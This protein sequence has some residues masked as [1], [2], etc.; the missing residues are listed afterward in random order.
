VEERVKPN[1]FLPSVIH[2]IPPLTPA[3]ALFGLCCYQR[4]PPPSAFTRNLDFK[5]RQ[6]ENPVGGLLNATPLIFLTIRVSKRRR[7][8]P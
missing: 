3:G 8:S 5:S 7:E 2:H 6:R 4:H 1:L